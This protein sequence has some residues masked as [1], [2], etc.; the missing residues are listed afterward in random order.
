ME[1]CPRQTGLGARSFETAMQFRRT[2]QASDIDELGHVNNAVYVGWLQDAALAHWYKMT[3]GPLKD[4][5]VWICL[6]HEID[7]RLPVLPGEEVEL[8][9]W[10]GV[11]HGARFDRHTDI[12]KVGARRS[13]VEAVTTWVM[14]EKATGRP[15]RVGDDVMEAFGLDVAHHTSTES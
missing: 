10:L 7:Y 4:G 11:R 3:D 8:R 5:F 9:T 13:S 1:E 2:A 12:R 14:L 6:R 15:R